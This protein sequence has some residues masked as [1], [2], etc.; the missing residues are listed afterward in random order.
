MALTPLVAS[1]RDVT[2]PNP[3]SVTC[4]GG[5]RSTAFESFAQ[6]DV[7][8]V[9]GSRGCREEVKFESTRECHEA[10]GPAPKLIGDLPY[11]RGRKSLQGAC[12][13]KF[14]PRAD[15][16]GP[17]QGEHISPTPANISPII[18]NIP[19]PAPLSP[20]AL[21]SAPSMQHSHESPRFPKAPT[22]PVPL[23]RPVQKN[24]EPSS[25][26]DPR[27]PTAD[28]THKLRLSPPR[29]GAF[30]TPSPFGLPELQSDLNLKYTVSGL[31][32]SSPK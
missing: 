16:F 27:P 18:S 17:E 13:F 10:Q 28:E 25:P 19:T 20:A 21:N 14:E 15:L 6:Q 5:T 32:I 12:A 7:G 4:A 29:H 31:A 22:S 26:S 8:P 9:R 2:G 24:G 11:W 23:F 30:P 3:S 1:Y